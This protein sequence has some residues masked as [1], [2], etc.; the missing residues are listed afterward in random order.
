MSYLTRFL[1]REDASRRGRAGKP[2]APLLRLGIFAR[3]F[4]ALWTAGLDVGNSTFELTAQ[5]LLLV[6]P[7]PHTTMS[8][9]IRRQAHRTAIDAELNQELREAEGNPKIALFQ[10]AIL[11]ESKRHIE[12]NSCV[13]HHRE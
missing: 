8:A 10:Q 4:G 5:S 13:C 6:P 1:E 9:I 2:T 12:H 11:H 3:I 7:D